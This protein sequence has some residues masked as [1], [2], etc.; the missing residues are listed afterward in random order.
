MRPQ[1]ILIKLRVSP[2][3]NPK[4]KPFPRLLELSTYTVLLMKRRG[5][6]KEAGKW[7]DNSK[8]YNSVHGWLCSLHRKLTSTCIWVTQ[9]FKF[10]YYYND[11]HLK[12]K[13]MQWILLLELNSAIKRRLSAIS[14]TKKKNHH[15]CQGI[16][17]SWPR[18]LCTFP[19][20][21]WAVYHSHC[22]SGDRV[23]FYTQGYAECQG[24]SIYASHVLMLPHIFRVLC[25]HY[26]KP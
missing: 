25:K 15:F 3:A 22:A 6:E 5:G 11:L 20:E 13:K 21:G 10:L 12:K 7:R 14:R 17:M 18:C 16:R 19:N 23:L 2:W 4:W 24:N 9:V 8:M 26:V 1:T